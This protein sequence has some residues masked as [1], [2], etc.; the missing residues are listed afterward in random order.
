MKQLIVA[1]SL[2]ETWKNRYLKLFFSYR[3]MTIYQERE[4][5]SDFKV[6][7]VA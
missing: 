5:L 7:N 6:C 3:G 4:F 2:Y 1:K